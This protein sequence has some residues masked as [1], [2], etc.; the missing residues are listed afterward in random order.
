MTTQHR[1]L[2]A[3]LRGITPDEVVA[4]GQS[5]VA[6]G[7]TQIE[8]PLN[9][10]EPFQSIQRLVDALGASALIGAGTVLS[11]EQVEAVAASGGKLIVSPNCNVSVIERT[12]QLGLI[13]LP[14]VM[15][16]TECFQALEA[17]ADGL[18]FFPA[19][20]LG[21]SGLKAIKAVLPKQTRTYAV[22][23]VGA[24]EFADWFKAG[25]TGFGMGSALYQAPATV[26]I[27]ATHAQQLVIAYDAAQ[28]E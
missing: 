23:G 10:P 4:V 3:I 18:K 15:T 27:V 14:G 13:S 2:I 1:E 19:A 28:G 7:I 8:V 25:I 17:G 5:L 22:G 24:A 9:S 20:L 6:A 16:P 21:V 12:K 11:L 26:Q